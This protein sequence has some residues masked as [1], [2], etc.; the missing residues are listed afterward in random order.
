MYHGS[1]RGYFKYQII[2]LPEADHSS[3]FLYIL[4]IQ[5]NPQF[6]C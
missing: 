1:V 3:C 6:H 5:Y 4:K 2:F